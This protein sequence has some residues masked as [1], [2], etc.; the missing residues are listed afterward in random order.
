MKRIL[1]L[2]LFAVCIS[3]SAAQQPAAAAS[4]DIEI[5]KALCQ[6]RNKDY[7]GAQKTI[8]AVVRAEPQNLYARRLAPGI[9]GFQIKKNDRSPQNIAIIRRAIAAYASFSKSPGI[10]EKDQEHTD[11]EIVSLAGSVNDQ[12]D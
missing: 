9:I 3:S 8:D 2:F 1:T 4:S 11:Y 6:I 12:K 7:L 10:S 5:R